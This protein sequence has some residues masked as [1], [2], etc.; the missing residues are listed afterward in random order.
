MLRMFNQLTNIGFINW[1]RGFFPEFTNGQ[2]KIRY[3]MPAKKNKADSRS[4]VSIYEGIFCV[5]KQNNNNNRNMSEMK[6]K[7]N[8]NLPNTL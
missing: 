7:K 8:K 1:K 2:V 3:E 5:T 4:S 6:T